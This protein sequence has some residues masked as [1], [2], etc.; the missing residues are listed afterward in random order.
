M[1]CGKIQEVEGIDI[2]DE[3]ARKLT[4]RDKALV[5]LGVY[6]FIYHRQW[7]E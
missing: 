2:S 7:A 6:M 3:R 5:K 4:N 1:F